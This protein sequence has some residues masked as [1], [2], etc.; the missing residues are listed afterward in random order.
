MHDAM[1]L[2]SPN[3]PSCDASNQR[4]GGGAAGSG[5]GDPGG[6]GAEAVPFG[7]RGFFGVSVFRPAFGGGPAGGSFAITGLGS[8]LVEPG[9][10]K[11]PGIRTTC[12]GT[13]TGWNLGSV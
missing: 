6:G 2:Q 1:G 12:T 7:A 4:V 11:S 13:V 8:R 10:E 3:R 9:E 5:K